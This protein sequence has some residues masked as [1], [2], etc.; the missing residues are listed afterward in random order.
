MVALSDDRAVRQPMIDGAVIRLARPV[1]P[2]EVAAAARL[3]VEAGQ[4]ITS[5]PLGDRVAPT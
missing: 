3:L 2:S 5:P 4:C 1:S